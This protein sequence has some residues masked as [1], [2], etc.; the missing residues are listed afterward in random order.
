MS[1]KVGNCARIRSSRV[2]NLPLNELVSVRI[3]I[4]GIAYKVGKPVL[5]VPE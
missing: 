4:D 2:R 5:P 3:L 1:S